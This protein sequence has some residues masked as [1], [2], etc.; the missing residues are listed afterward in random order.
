VI[1]SLSVASS[2][3]ANGRRCATHFC[4]LALHSI[5][6]F[7]YS[8]PRH[9]PQAGT[10]DEVLSDG[11]AETG[12]WFATRS[13]EEELHHFRDAARFHGS[14]EQLCLQVGFRGPVE[15][16]RESVRE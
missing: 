9:H 16:A 10:F 5:A 13:A 2:L 6:L 4:S 1:V 14:I 7:I 3:A 12:G 11:N 8:A 15:K